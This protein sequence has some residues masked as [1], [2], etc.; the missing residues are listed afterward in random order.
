L[1]DGRHARPP[2]PENSISSR[3]RPVGLFFEGVV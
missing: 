2:G 3:F 1:M